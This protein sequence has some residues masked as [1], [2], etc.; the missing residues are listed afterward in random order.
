MK[1][2]DPD[3]IIDETWV[4]RARKAKSFTTGRKSRARINLR[5]PV[6]LYNQILTEAAKREWSVSRM[7][8]HLCE[9]SIEGIE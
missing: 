8:R 5:L 1:P 9:A 3:H 7:I 2:F 6:P 4:I